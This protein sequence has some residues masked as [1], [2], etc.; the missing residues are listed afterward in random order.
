[1]YEAIVGLRHALRTGARSFGIGN[2][3]VVDDLIDEAFDRAVD[4]VCRTG[5]PSRPERLQAWAVAIL[6][7]LV[8][9]GPPRSTLERR[10]HVEV[11]PAVS[12]SDPV[13]CTPGSKCLLR[14]LPVVAYATLTPAELRAFNALSGA[15]SVRAAAATARMS[16]RDLRTR[17]R[18]STAKLR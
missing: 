17:S 7:N 5:G 13:R 2:W 6:H 10:G 14:D 1:S 16:P 4:R 11:D 15:R 3:R 12:G 9:S 18:R 8:R